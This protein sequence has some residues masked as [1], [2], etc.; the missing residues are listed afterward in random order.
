[1]REGYE[2]HT[3]MVRGLLLMKKKSSTFIAFP[4]CPPAALIR[5]NR[6]N[7]TQFSRKLDWLVSKLE[8]LESSSGIMHM[9][10][11]VLHDLPFHGNNYIHILCANAKVWKPSVRC[12][13]V[14]TRY[15][16]LYYFPM[17][18]VQ[19]INSNCADVCSVWT[20]CGYPNICISPNI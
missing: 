6:P 10:T 20:L 9:Y 7:C 5:G 4:S 2:G 19:Q 14:C 18:S 17:C 16:M 8:R 1:M 12:H 3:V 15:F 13:N 11:H